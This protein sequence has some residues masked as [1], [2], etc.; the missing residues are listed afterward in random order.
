MKAEKS[1][2][3]P[4]GLALA[5]LLPKDAIAVGVQGS[6]ELQPAT[7]PDGVT[8]GAR[9]RQ[10]LVARPSGVGTSRA[11]VTTRLVATLTVKQEVPRPRVA[12][13]GATGRF[14]ATLQG[15]TLYWR[16]S[17]ANLS[18]PSV[19]AVVHK[20]A[21][22]TIGPRTRGLCGPCKSIVSGV[23][24]LS[25]SEVTDLLAGRLYVNVGTR[26]NVHGEIRGRIHRVVPAVVEP[27]PAP[28]IGGHYSHVSHVSHVSHY[29]HR[30]HYSSSF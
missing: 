9:V 25:S 26:V 18:S 2:L 8:L 4:F 27:A 30:S 10:T 7:L 21:P 15:R 12:G 16:L 11:Q 19:A 6:R 5:G 14:T 24:V 17:V 3:V 23:A 1:F 13:V 22:S 29:S 28:S 20:G